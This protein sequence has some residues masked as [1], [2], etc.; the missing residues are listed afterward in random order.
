VIVEP[1]KKVKKTKT[2]IVEVT[3]NLYVSNN[4][5]E[6]KEA[7]LCERYFPESVL[8]FK[9][10]HKSLAESPFKFSIEVHLI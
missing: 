7:S 4:E 3:Y 8:D 10:I 1:V 9:V 5:E 2:K 6:L